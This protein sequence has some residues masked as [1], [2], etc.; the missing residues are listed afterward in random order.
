[1][2]KI[3]RHYWDDIRKTLVLYSLIPALALL[4]L[5]YPLLYGSFLSTMY[6]SNETSNQTLARELESAL[7]QQMEGAEALAQDPSIREVLTQA[8]QADSVEA[9]RQIYARLNRNALEA[10]CFV[11]NDRGETVLSTKTVV[12]DYLSGIYFSHS[13]I[14]VRMQR[15]PGKT[16]IQR[17]GLTSAHA[18]QMC[19]GRAVVEEKKIIGYV[20][21]DLSEE[22]ITQLL[23]Q[24][25]SETCA[26]TDEFGYLFAGSVNDALISHEKLLP[27]LREGEQKVQMEGRSQY[28]SSQSILG[29]RVMVYT[30]TDMGYLHQMFWSTAALLLAV[31]VVF[32]LLLMLASQRF[33]RRKSQDLEEMLAAMQTVESGDLDKVLP[34]ESRHEFRYFAEA[35]N[36]MLVEL[37]KLME[38]NSEIARQTAVAEMK[39]LESQFNPHFL[40][41]TLSAIRYMVDFEPKSAQKMISNV[42]KILRY[43]VGTEGSLVRLGDDL[44]Y[45]VNYI[46]IMSFRYGDSL[47]FT[48]DIAPEARD[49]QIPKLAMQ[50]VIEN[51]IKYGFEDTASITISIRAEIQNGLLVLTIHNSGT[52]MDEAQLETVRQRLHTHNPHSRHI[53]LSNV[54]RRVQLLFGEEYGVEVNSAVGAGTTV[55]I[56]LPAQRGDKHD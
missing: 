5:G 31:A 11:L 15:N 23:L 8:E 6:R 41:N 9:Y 10:N 27:S 14:G 25:P 7:H 42:S 1:M 39:Q 21:L 26:I 16:M 3:F 50:P 37:K 44:E 12:P 51:A 47:L 28:V 13:G 18:R 46:E 33:A 40:Y 20:V 53:G 19:I 35:Y 17:V 48:L 29:G 24:N 36:R 49:C 2:D 56:R 52:G 22:D 45:T 38:V 4:L 43:S 30:I 55:T 34:M 32:T 54:H